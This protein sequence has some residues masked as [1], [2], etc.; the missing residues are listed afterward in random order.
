MPDIAM[1]QTECEQAK[2]CYRFWAT[3]YEHWQSWFSSD[4]RNADGSCE[5]YY[6]RPQSPNKE[7]VD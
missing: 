3:P 1:C 6:R 4:P 5:H 2:T 7:G